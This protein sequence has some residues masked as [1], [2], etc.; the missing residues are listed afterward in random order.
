MVLG[1][2]DADKD[3]FEKSNSTYLPQWYT[4][5]TK[6]DLTGKPRQVIKFLPKENLTIFN[7]FRRS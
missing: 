7:I 4:N 5:G 3:N 2:H 1:I 6:C